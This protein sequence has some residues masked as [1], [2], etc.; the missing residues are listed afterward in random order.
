MKEEKLFPV[1]YDGKKYYKK[2]CDDIFLS[3]Y[4]CR[5]ALNELGG[6]YMTEDTWV[7]PDGYMNEY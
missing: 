1:L 2:D 4:F 6:V 3:F 7:Y 5:E